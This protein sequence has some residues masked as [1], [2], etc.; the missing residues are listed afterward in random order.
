MAETFTLE[1]LD[2]PTISPYLGLLSIT[3]AAA[4]VSNRAGTL[5]AL[6]EMSIQTGG[7]VRLIPELGYMPALIGNDNEPVFLYQVM[8]GL[9]E[10]LDYDALLAEYP[11][12]D[13]SQIAGAVSFLRKVSQ[14]NCRDIDV[15]E[16]ED[17]FDFGNGEFVGRLREAFEN[18]GNVARVLPDN[19]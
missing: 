14:T 10:F 3:Q 16:L 17:T 8:E 19:I 1:P 11:T 9:D 13:F 4:N 15:D 6:T 12:L 18:R 2:A 7:Y 5:L